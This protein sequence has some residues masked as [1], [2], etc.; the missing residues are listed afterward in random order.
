MRVIN[1]IQRTS[2][3]GYSTPQPFLVLITIDLRRNREILSR[4][5]TASHCLAPRNDIPGRIKLTYLLAVLSCLDLHHARR[6]MLPAPSRPPRLRAPHWRCVVDGKLQAGSRKA[7]NSRASTR[8]GGLPKAGSLAAAA[9]HRSWSSS[10]CGTST[11]S[12]ERWTRPACGA[13]P[14]MEELGSISSRNC[15]RARPCMR[16]GAT[17]GGS[18]HARG[19]LRTKPLWPW[20][21]L[22][23]CRAGGLGRR[24]SF[25]STLQG[26]TAVARENTLQR[27]RRDTVV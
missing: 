6:P 12:R 25:H 13:T 4:P 15:G 8:S 3:A 5:S 11:R 20:G 17:R 1:M 21:P 7:A 26:N 2:H 23:A 24:L 22:N 10:D 27:W 19:G 14:A 16:Q 9:G 18:A